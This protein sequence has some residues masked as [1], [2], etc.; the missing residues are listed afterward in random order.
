M[1]RPKSNNFCVT[2]TGSASYRWLARFSDAKTLGVSTANWSKLN[3]RKIFAIFG[4]F[5]L[6]LVRCWA[7]SLML[8]PLLVFTRL[9]R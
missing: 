3:D 2:I 7:I 5:L 4:E 8:L 1:G 6:R 9:S